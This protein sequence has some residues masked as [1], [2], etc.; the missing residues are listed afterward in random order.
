VIGQD[1]AKKVLSVAVH[2][3]CK[4][5]NHQTK[6][7]DVEILLIGQRLEAENPKKDSISRTWTMRS[8]DPRCGPLKRPFTRLTD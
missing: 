2:S 1:H 5:L 4:R 7:R 3:Q 6:H 8:D